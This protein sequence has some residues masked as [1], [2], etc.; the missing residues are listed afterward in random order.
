MGIGAF[1]IAIS[2]KPRAWFRNWIVKITQEQ[3][4][5]E[6][7]P[8]SEKLDFLTKKAAERDEDEKIKLGHSIMTIY[9]R[10][11]A[12]GY[13]TLADRKDLIELEHRYKDKN[14]NHHVDDY[15]HILMSM[16]VE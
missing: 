15:Y 14:G 12:R 9:D 6:L 7:A 3:I 16:K 8:I 11:I 4:K 1:I 2:K 13:I 10:S 5:T